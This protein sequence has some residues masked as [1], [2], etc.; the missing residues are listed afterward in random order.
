MQQTDTS[1]KMEKILQE[2]TK[3]IGSDIHPIDLKERINHTPINEVE[4]EGLRGQSMCRP[5]NPDVQ[6]LLKKHGVEGIKYSIQGE[7]DFSPVA[8]EKV[9]ISDMNEDL[10]HDYSSTI[11]KLLDTDFAKKNNIQNPTQMRKYLQ[12]HNL[13]I[14]EAQDGVTEF[15]LDRKV[16]ETFRHTG[17]RAKYKKYNNVDKDRIIKTTL[18]KQEIKINKKIVKTE[19][20]IDNQSKSIENFINK[21]VDSKAVNYT[22]QIVTY[23]TAISTTQNLIDVIK[24]DISIDEAAINITQT[25]LESKILS[26]GTYELANQ[27][28]I[29]QFNANIIISGVSELTGQVINYVNN[30][31]SEEEMKKN[32]TQI[33]FRIAKQYTL[34]FAAKLLNFT[35]PISIG[36]AI[37]QVILESVWNEIKDTYHLYNIY[38]QKCIREIKLCRAA[39]QEINIAKKRLEFILQEEN[40][41]LESSINSGF[42]MLLDGIINNSYNQIETGLIE[43]GNNFGLTSEDLKKCTIKKSNLFNSDEIIIFE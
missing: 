12:E 28:N 15:I 38:N 22:T 31:I 6:K 39:E 11:S 5:T 14:H 25:T 43:I 7:P 37:S 18:S 10:T 32:I 26:I 27:L 21:H 33:A 1:K 23:S 42:D 41:K 3:I 29:N 30:N 2:G 13:T 34:K 9:R 8:Y 16:H 17:G 35:N 36:M 20:F 24:N 40:K 4:W 19:E